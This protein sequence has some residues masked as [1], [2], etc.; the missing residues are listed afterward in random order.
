MTQDPPSLPY[1]QNRTSPASPVK[2]DDKTNYRFEIQ[3]NSEKDSDLDWI[4][5]PWTMD[6]LIIK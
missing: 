3:L 5:A 2:E 4:T 1:P 6:I